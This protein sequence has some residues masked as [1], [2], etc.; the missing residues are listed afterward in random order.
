MQLANL[1][2]RH[3]RKGFDCGE[4]V[5]NGWLQQNA[6]QAQR[7]KLSATFVAVESEESPCIMGFYALTMHLMD[8]G[9]LPLP[10]K[11][12]PRLVP[13]FLLARLAVDTRHKGRSIARHMVFDANR[14]ARICC[15]EVGGI[16]LLVDAKPSAVGFY[17]ACGFVHMIDRPDSLLL[18][19]V[20]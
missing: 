1:D 16:G 6:L 10:Y 8:G 13:I 15:R 11:N 17:E 18:P 3:D 4:Q 20:D 12:L 5:L 19:F 7:K 14:R 2:S 9:K